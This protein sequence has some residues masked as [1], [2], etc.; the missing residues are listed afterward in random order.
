[1]P[2][3]MTAPSDAP[4]AVPEPPRPRRSPSAVLWPLAGLVAAIAV[5]WLATVVFDIQKVIHFVEDNQ[6]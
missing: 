3:T 5:W 1:M 2:E 6:V 4:V